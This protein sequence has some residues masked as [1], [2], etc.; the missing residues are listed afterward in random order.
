MKDALEI[1]IFALIGFAAVFGAGGLFLG[2]LIAQIP[3]RF[4][5]NEKVNSAI[6]FGLGIPLAILGGLLG[7][8]IYLW[9]VSYFARNG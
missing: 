3:N 1:D 5:K 7:I 2:F 6:L 8:L 4:I 9:G